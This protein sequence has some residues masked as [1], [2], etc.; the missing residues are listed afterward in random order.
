MVF[1]NWPFYPSCLFTDY[2]NATELCVKI[3]IPWSRG[4]G[5]GSENKINLKQ[6]AA[7]TLLTLKYDDSAELWHVINKIMNLNNCNRFLI[8]SHVNQILKMSEDLLQIWLFVRSNIQTASFE[9]H[10]SCFL[11][12]HLHRNTQ[13]ICTEVPRYVSFVYLMMLQVSKAVQHQG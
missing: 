11:L 5:E 7:K 3:R 1:K 4:K 9:T 8:F 6:T 10:C 12:Q 13:E 2:I